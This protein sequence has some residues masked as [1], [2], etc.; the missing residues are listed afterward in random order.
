MNLTFKNEYSFWIANITSPRMTWILECALEP[1]ATGIFVTLHSNFLDSDLEGFSFPFMHW[2]VLC[3]LFTRRCS[4]W[5][6]SYFQSVWERWCERTIESG[7]ETAGAARKAEQCFLRACFSKTWYEYVT[8]RKSGYLAQSPY[9]A[10]IYCTE[11]CILPN[12][13]WTVTFIW[14]FFLTVINVYC[15]LVVGLS[16]IVSVTSH[17][18]CSYIIV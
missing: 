7:I 9:K 11:T 18:S 12:S 4:W 14:W 5:L 2:F 10:I 13:F 15:I 3:L 1:I 6:I 8:C 16:W 17:R